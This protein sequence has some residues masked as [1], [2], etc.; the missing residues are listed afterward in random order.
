MVVFVMRKWI[1][2]ALMID[3]ALYRLPLS[4]VEFDPDIDEERYNGIAI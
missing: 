2:T 3:R 1:M 4:L